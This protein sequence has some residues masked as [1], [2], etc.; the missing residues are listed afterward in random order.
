MTDTLKANL[1][2]RLDEAFK[3]ENAY[4]PDKNPFADFL[5]K[6]KQAHV[7]RQLSAWRAAPENNGK[8]PEDTA[9]QETK[10]REQ[11]DKEKLPEL[12]KQLREK[13]LGV[14]DGK[15]EVK[16]D[17][18]VNNVASGGISGLLSGN[19]LGGLMASLQN[20]MV[21]LVL[22]I[23]WVGDKIGQIST[24]IGS[25][26]SSWSSG[27]PSLGWQEAGES[28]KKEKVIKRM[29][30]G[31]AQYADAEKL[32]AMVEQSGS[33]ELKKPTMTVTVATERQASE[34]PAEQ[35]KEATEAAKPA[36]ETGMSP[37]PDTAAG[38][39]YVMGRFFGKPVV[40]RRE[41]S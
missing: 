1:D 37:A 19:F 3:L 34:L 8:T 24:F 29:Q 7:E 40:V 15:D 9:A 26:F 23:P 11:F 20:A 13:S 12:T 21:G 38:E 18:V 10:L 6:Q 41:I 31:L 30:D 5:A 32:R 27:Q 39:Q 2:T 36:A 14:Y 22:S 25:K 17:G 4:N 16:V 33:P 35:K 28:Y